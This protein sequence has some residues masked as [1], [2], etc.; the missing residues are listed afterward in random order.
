M[1]KWKELKTWIGNE[2]RAEHSQIHTSVSLSYFDRTCHIYIYTLI[3]NKWIN[4]SNCT[5]FLLEHIIFLILTTCRSCWKIN[6]KSEFNEASN[7]KY[8][9]KE[10][11]WCLIEESTSWFMVLIT[12]FIT[13]SFTIFIF[14]HSLSSRLPADP[15][16][17][18]H[19]EESK[20]YLPQEFRKKKVIIKTCARLEHIL[21]WF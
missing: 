16:S 17:R 7:N 19:L 3:L 6:N 2:Q 9:Y 10:S 11:T 4:K 21:D 5:L 1:V 18:Y 13:K 15:P 8:S 20:Q 12:V 14:W